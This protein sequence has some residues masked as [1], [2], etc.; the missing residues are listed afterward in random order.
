MKNISRS[1]IL[2]A[3]AFS[4]LVLR[5]HAHP[6][7]TDPALSELN[8]YLPAIQFIKDTRQTPQATELINQWLVV[9]QATWDLM[10]MMDKEGFVT[11]SPEVVVKIAN[12]KNDRQRLLEDCRS[13]FASQVDLIPTIKIDLA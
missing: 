2:I 5:C 10:N 13:F 11:D 3:A 9:R 12:S 4:I 8:D 7:H 6:R 1:V